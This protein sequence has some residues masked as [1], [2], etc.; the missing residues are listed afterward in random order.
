MAGETRFLVHLDV[1][2]LEAEPKP[3]ASTIKTFALPAACVAK[4]KSN[5]TFLVRSPLIRLSCHV[6]L[7]ASL[8]RL[9]DAAGGDERAPHLGRRWTRL[10]LGRARLLGRWLV[11]SSHSDRNTHCSSGAT[12]EAG[13]TAAAWAGGSLP[14]IH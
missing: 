6:L 1:L 14:L 3:D 2:N 13:A 8:T 10:G 4:L 9:A 5:E 7:C 11:L 12:V